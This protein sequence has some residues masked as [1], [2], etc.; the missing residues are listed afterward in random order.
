M[1][2]CRQKDKTNFFST[3]LRISC[4]KKKKQLRIRK[5]QTNP[6]RMIL[7]IFFTDDFPK[8]RPPKSNYFPN[9]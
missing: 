8:F 6:D 1:H 4:V 3:P 9:P 7:F 2:F 5:F